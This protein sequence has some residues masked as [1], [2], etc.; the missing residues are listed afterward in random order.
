MKVELGNLM[1][2]KQ[3]F[4][5]EKGGRGSNFKLLK[6]VMF[7]M[8]FSCFSLSSGYSQEVQAEQRNSTR[9]IK[10]SALVA[11]AKSARL[12]KTP[13][14][15]GSSEKMSSNT[16]EFTKW[17]SMLARYDQ[18]MKGSESA[19][20]K[21]WFSRL[22][23]LKDADI[24]VQMRQVNNIVN[25]NRYVGDLDGTGKSDQW[26]TP[27]E[28]IN[29]RFGDCEDYAITKFMTLKALGVSESSMR[30]V[31][32]NDTY[33]G[34]PHAILVVYANGTSYVLDNQNTDI[35]ETSQISHYQPVYSISRF[36]WWR[37]FPGQ[38]NG[39]TL[40]ANR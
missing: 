31:V 3:R 24:R 40:V 12:V 17:T 7:F 38:Q 4:M 11:P 19:T 34:I 21:A 20:F 14:I 13:S 28:M 22:E 30:I 32:V 15:F 37:H 33:K 35:V 27:V 36:A 26:A 16:G 2:E 8:I 23:Y 9:S 29:A 18:Q 5:R 25:L 6:A 39:Q 1:N 10:L